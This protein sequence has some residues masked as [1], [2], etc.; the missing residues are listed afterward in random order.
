MSAKHLIGEG[1][2]LPDIALP[3]V[4]GRPLRL[5]SFRGKRLFV[6]MWASW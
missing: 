4:N 1:D 3:D 5:S 2:R 6:F